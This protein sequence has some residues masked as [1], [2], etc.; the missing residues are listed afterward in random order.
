MSVFRFRAFDSTGNEVGDKVEAETQE[1]A[2]QEI[3]KRGFFVTWIKQ[4]GEGSE[5]EEKATLF[6]ETPE[7]TE[8]PAKETEEDVQLRFLREVQEQL[9][10]AINVEPIIDLESL[11]N[12]TAEGAILKKEDEILFLAV[13]AVADQIRC[14]REMWANS[15]SGITSLMQKA[16]DEERRRLGS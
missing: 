12:R 4:D 14:L 9:G 1:G 16:A 6:R 13:L 5:S 10:Q 2:L 11:V 7:E 3:R 8:E 15:Q